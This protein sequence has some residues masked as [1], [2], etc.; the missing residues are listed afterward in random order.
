VQLADLATSRARLDLMP[1][2]EAPPISP[3]WAAAAFYRAAV[4]GWVQIW[5][6]L[7]A[8]PVA[9]YFDLRRLRRDQPSIECI[10]HTIPASTVPTLGGENLDVGLLAGG[11]VNISVLVEVSVVAHWGDVIMPWR[12]I[13][14]ECA[15]IGDRP[16]IAA[17]HIDIREIKAL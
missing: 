7:D 4:G 11:E 14:I 2:I 8:V 15:S 17:I 13:A 3:S 9:S 1:A 6:P 10:A 12:D 5:R 16:E